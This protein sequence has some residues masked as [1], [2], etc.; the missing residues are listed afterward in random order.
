MP[1]KANHPGRPRGTR[2]YER[3]VSVFLSRD[4]LDLVEERRAHDKTTFSEAVRRCLQDH[5]ASIHLEDDDR[6]LVAI[7]KQDREDLRRLV[8]NGLVTTEAHAATQ[9]IHDYIVH[10]IAERKE[11]EK[12]L[13]AA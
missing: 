3:Q 9:A 10:V 5:S 13:G 7:S 11:R 12:L 8:Q 4:L 2:R 6:I 1:R